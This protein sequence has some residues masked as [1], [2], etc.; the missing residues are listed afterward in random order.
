MYAAASQIKYLYL[1]YLS[2]PACDRTIYRL[3]RKRR[4]ASIVELG[5]GPGKRAVRMIQV[6]QSS[7]LPAKA[8]Q[9]RYTGIDEFELR[10]PQ[11][12]PGLSLKDAHRLLRATT[13][14]VQVVPGDPRT[15]LTRVA[16]TLTNTDLVIISGGHDPES[17][18]QAWFY[19]PRMLHD[20]SLV[21]VEE[22]TCAGPPQRLRLVPRDEVEALAAQTRR[23]AA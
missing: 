3:I 16:N 11:A 21:F 22:R 9:V 1:A 20:Q 8:G 6:A 12:G 10:S 7:R 18:Q 13:A 15:A 5:L 14:K 2:A 19:I 4:I 23:R 17:L